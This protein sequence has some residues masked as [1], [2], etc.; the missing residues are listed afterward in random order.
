MAI[1]MSVAGASGNWSP[2]AQYL[3]G[4]NGSLADQ[5]QGE[6]EQARKRRLAALAAAQSKIG[7]AVGGGYGAAASPA[8]QSLGFGV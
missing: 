7:A 2:A 6:D 4:M 8:A 1:G 3:N 5:A